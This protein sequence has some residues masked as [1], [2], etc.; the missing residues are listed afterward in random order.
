LVLTLAF[1]VCFPA[2][3]VPH[4]NLRDGPFGLHFNLVTEYEHGWPLRYASR[5]L[6]H[7]TAAEGPPSAWR[8]WEGPGRFSTL[9]LVVDLGFWMLV[10]IAVG[11]GASWWRAQRRAL[12]QM[13]L[14]DLL[15]LTGLAGLAFAWLA[16]QRAEYLR[17]RAL[18]AQLRLRPGHA[19]QEHQVGARVPAWWPTSWQARYR[20][21]FNRPCYFYS[22]GDTDIACQHRHVIALRELTFHPEFPQHLQKMQGL[23]AIDLCFVEFPYF[24]ATRQTTIL[25][26]LAP[27]A[28]L[29]GINLST[30]NAT[31]ADMAWLASCPLLEVIDL[32][33][34]KIGDRGLAQLARL[35][36]LRKLSISSDRISDRGCQSIGHM[37]SLEVLSLASRN[38]HDEGARELANLIRLK[39]L[40]ISAATTDASHET[41]RRA[42]PGCEFKGSHYPIA[43][44]PIP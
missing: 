38:I 1:L 24:D 17:E 3:E 14:R 13:G 32:G 21:L 34:T 44:S 6:S 4:A 36:R 42:L 16:D 8:P 10:A 25:R 43:R 41:L 18:V 12:W 33:E 28:N 7:R 40:Q 37:V 27:L 11:V 20:E 15:V 31:D 2:V 19:T 23:E 30:T 5:D 29:R 9:N 35:P 26:D 39:R 22:S